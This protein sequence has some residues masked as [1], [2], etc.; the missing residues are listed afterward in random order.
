MEFKFKREIA[1]TSGLNNAVLLEYITNY[2]LQKFMSSKVPNYKTYASIYK[3]FEYKT[4][5]PD[6]K[7]ESFFNLVEHI[8]TNDKDIKLSETIFTFCFNK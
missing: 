2:N 1:E 8:T 5:S 4:L 6:E 7:T 3:L